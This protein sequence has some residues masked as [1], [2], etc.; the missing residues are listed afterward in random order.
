MGVAR[1]GVTDQDRVRRV[2]VEGAPR[3]VGDGHIAQ[4]RTALDGVDY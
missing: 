4:D 2:V 3:L 1:P